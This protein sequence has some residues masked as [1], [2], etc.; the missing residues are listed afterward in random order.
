MMLQGCI[1][2]G[3]GSWVFLSA[4]CLVAGTRE[5]SAQST[6]HTTDILGSFFVKADVLRFR[7][8]LDLGQVPHT[9]QWFSLSL[10]ELSLYKLLLK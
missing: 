4:W 7:D 2:C 5:S 1:S 9:N 6:T 10:L 8:W 3:L